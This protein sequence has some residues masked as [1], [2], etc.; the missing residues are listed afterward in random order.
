MVE[1]VIFCNIKSKSVIPMA[2]V[3]DLKNL[4]SL[5]K[6]RIPMEAYIRNAVIAEG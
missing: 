3:Q 5:A 6:V 2:T 4:K 1:V